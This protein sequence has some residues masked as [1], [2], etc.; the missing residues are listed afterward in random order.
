[1]AAALQRVGDFR[2]HVLLVVLGKD[3]AGDKDPVAAQFAL[4]NNALALAEQ[5][6]Q[7]TVIHDLEFGLAVGHPESH[8]TA[9]LFY[10][11][12]VLDQP[13]DANAPLRPDRLLGEIARSEER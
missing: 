10:Q 1:M 9:I 8:P 4:G 2:R 13:A 11:A 3:A 7:Q 6:G 12:L 5:I